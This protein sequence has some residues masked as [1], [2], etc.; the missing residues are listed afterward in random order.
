MK[1]IS[2]KLKDQI[3]LE[4]EEVL[5]HLTASRNS[6]IND[7]IDFYNKHQR[8]KLIAAQLEMESKLVS[9]DSM[10]VLQEFEQLEDE[11]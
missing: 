1:S 3:L 2:L 9:D 8:R 7:A 10:R 4:A 5:Q 6:Y 11:V